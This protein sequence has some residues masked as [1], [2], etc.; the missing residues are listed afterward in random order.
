MAKQFYR[1]AIQE[2]AE[3]EGV[4][5]TAQAARFDIPRSAL[6]YAVSSGL[7]ERIAHGAYRLRGTQSGLDDEAAAA[8][9]ATDPG[10][11]TSERFRADAWD[12]I[13]IGGTSAAA[14]LG[15]GDFHLSP[16]CLLTPRRFNTRRED[17]YARRR[18]VNRCDVSFERGFPV[19]CPE[20]TI[21]DLMIDGEDPSQVADAFA[22]AC[23]RAFDLDRF[24]SLCREHFGE[25]RGAAIFADL[26][27][28]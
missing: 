11:I 6:S 16:V 21:L 24:Q 26:V 2:L 19:T 1:A 23:H 10:K 13:A 4:F 22:D 27:S 15:I 3:T 9:K 18:S 17:I 20:R 7:V 5:T 25:G 28:S 8:W 12:G 14:L